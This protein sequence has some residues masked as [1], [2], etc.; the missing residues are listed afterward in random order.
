M[1][2]L[3]LGKKIAKYFKSKNKSQYSIQE[4]AFFKGGRNSKPTMP[5]PGKC[6]KGQG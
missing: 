3:K 2:L 5:R 6:P 1:G 4:G